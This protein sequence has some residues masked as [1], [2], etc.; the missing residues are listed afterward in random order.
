MARCARSALGPRLRGEDGF[1]EI[2]TNVKTT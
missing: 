1:L 2:K